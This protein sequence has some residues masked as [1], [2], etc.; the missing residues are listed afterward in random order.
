MDC[1]TINNILWSTESTFWNVIMRPEGETDDNSEILCITCFVIRVDKAGYA[2]LWRL[3][4]EFHWETKNE[5]RA[6][7]HRA[8]GEDCQSGNGSAC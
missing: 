6:R 7:K 5:K 3:T 2:P 8:I 4:P 1:G